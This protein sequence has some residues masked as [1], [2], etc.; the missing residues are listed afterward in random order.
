MANIILPS[1]TNQM[2]LGIFKYLVD[3]EL[4]KK[5]AGCLDFRFGCQEGMIVTLSLMFGDVDDQTAELAY[6][7][8][9]SW[10]QITEKIVEAKLSDWARK[11]ENLDNDSDTTELDGLNEAVEQ[12]VEDYALQHPTALTDAL[13][14]L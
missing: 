13:S 1:L 11:L 3:A 4:R 5:I 6:E 10:L 14:N 2:V 8:Q 7:K 12:A 9:K